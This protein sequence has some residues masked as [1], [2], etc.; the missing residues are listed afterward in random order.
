M[1][2]YQSAY[3]LHYSTETVISVVFNEIARTVDAGHIGLCTMAMLDLSAAFDTVDHVLNER[4][5][6]AHRMPRCSQ[7]LIPIISDR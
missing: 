7:R 1:S 4:S 3:R 2:K 6:E 5:R